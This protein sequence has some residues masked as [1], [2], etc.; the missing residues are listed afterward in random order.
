ML[1]FDQ[2]QAKTQSLSKALDSR[3]PS[4]AKELDYYRGNQGQLKF[5]SEKFNAQFQQQFAGFSDNWC[6]PVADAA[7]ERMTVLGI[8]PFGQTKSD[9]DMNRAWERSNAAAGMHT[10][11]VVRS[12]ARRSFALVAPGKTEDVPRITFESPE[13]TIV[14]VDP[15]TRE[16][17]AALITWADDKVEY[18]TLYMPGEIWKFHRPSDRERWER[19]GKPVELTGGWQIRDTDP[20]PVTANPFGEVPVVEFSNRDLL[21]DEPMSEISGVMAM[22]D[23]INLIWAY[24]INALDGVSLPQR[25]VTGAEP[26]SIPVLDKDGKVVGKRPVELDDLLGEKILWVPSQSA[27]AQEWSASVLEPFSKVISQAVE[28]IAAQTRTPPHYLMSRMVNT[29]AEAL[30]ISEAGLV[31]K[32]R[33]AVNHVSPEVRELYKLM[34]IAMRRPQSQVD[35][36]AAGKVMWRDIQYRSEAQRADALL[37]KRQMGYPL[38][39]IFEQDGLDP[40]EIDRVML[41]IS[42]EQQADPMGTLRETVNTGITSDSPDEPL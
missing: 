25:I 9:D 39:W 30:T 33:Q 35:A 38:R 28:H 18:A 10:A 12:A 6:A 23:A 3:R 14:D 32:T 37:K 41:M 29:S 17:R 11:M 36:L 7:P 40:E 13:S 20:D 31:S 42:E 22:Q 1:T 34:A 4:T 27:K 26:P 5:A 15:A 19:N 16:R 24:L 21:D 2:A 8:R